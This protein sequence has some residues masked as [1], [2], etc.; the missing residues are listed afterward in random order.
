MNRARASRGFTLVELLIVIVVIAILAAITIVGYGNITNRAKFA[1]IQGNLTEGSQGL[2]AYQSENGAYPVSLTSVSASLGADPTYSYSANN[3]GSGFCLQAATGT[4]QYYVT[5]TNQTVQTG[6][7][8]NQ[9]GG[10]VATY[11]N[12]YNNERGLAYDSSG[13]LF[14]ADGGNNCIR[15]LSSSKQLTTF[16]GTCGSANGTTNGTGTAASFANPEGIRIDASGSIYVADSSNNCIRKITSAA[17][18]TTL[19]GS[20][21]SAHGFA[22]GTGTAATFYSPNDLYVD[23]SGNVFVADTGNNAIRE[24]TPAGVVTTFA[25]TG[26]GGTVDGSAASATFLNPRG[27]TGDSAGNIYVADYGNDCIRKISG[28]I[29]STIAGTCGTGGYA[30]GTAATAL[31]NAPTALAMSTSNNLY[32]VDTS[33]NCVRR[34]S[35]AAVVSTV[36]GSCNSAAGTNSSLTGTADGVGP[37]ALF[38]MPR[39]VVISPSNLLMVAD[40]GNNAIRTIQL[41]SL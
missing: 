3:N 28:G 6:L 5:D 11:A 21:G 38:N 34:L 17:V 13:N 36:A 15:K 18:V 22:N 9:D 31:L 40:S 30:D 39:A 19:A 23:A 20:C 32:I 27:V 2:H 33:N 12:G 1:Q 7:C 41:S 29:V 35:P 37:S 8:P 4:L 16:A 25:G 24:V 26:A 14:I 10:I